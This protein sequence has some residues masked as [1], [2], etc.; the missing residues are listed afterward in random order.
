MAVSTEAEVAGRV[1]LHY[2]RGQ[3]MPSCK[4]LSCVTTQS[5]DLALTQKACQLQIA[6]SGRLLTALSMRMAAHRSDR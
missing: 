2:L 1:R 3:H 6:E 5:D 4:G